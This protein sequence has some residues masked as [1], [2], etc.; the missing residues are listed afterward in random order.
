MGLPLNTIRIP[1][2]VTIIMVF[3][4]RR[5]CR[6]AET[7]KRPQK[8]FLNFQKRIFQLDAISRVFSASKKCGLFASHSH[9]HGAET[10][11]GVIRVDIYFK[12]APRR[13]ITKAACRDLVAFFPMRAFRRSSVKPHAKAPCGELL[14]LQ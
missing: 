5:H 10:M 3:S 14:R 9:S 6:D 4:R 8:L 1:Q 12:C 2:V 13:A 11:R 7:N